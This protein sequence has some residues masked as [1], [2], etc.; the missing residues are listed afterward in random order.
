MKTLCA[1]VVFSFIA[2][3]LAACTAPVEIEHPELIGEASH[4]V[5]SDHCRV[6]ACAEA[7]RACENSCTDCETDCVI[8]GGSFDACRGIC[9]HCQS[10]CDRT[11]A[12]CAQTDYRFALSADRDEDIAD[13]CGRA[14][15]RDR[16]CGVSPVSMDCDIT[17]RTENHGRVAV[18]ECIARTPCGTAPACSPQT[19][20][21]IGDEFDS[22][23]RQWGSIIDSEVTRRLNEREPRLN[24]DVV[25]AF[26]ACIALGTCGDMDFCRQAW[27]QAV[28]RPTG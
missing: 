5:R 16:A 27:E 3:T 22:A 25:A 23:Y 26:R 2:A 19:A 12:P 17:A 1:A 10:S 15:Q 7:E 11:T 6:D 21:T 8:N 20:G 14:V 24:A 28:I 13:A 4:I 9:C 18:Y